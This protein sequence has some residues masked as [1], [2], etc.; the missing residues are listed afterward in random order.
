MK[1]VKL[2]K[3]YLIISYKKATMQHCIVYITMHLGLCTTFVSS[4]TDCCNTRSR[5]CMYI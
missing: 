4:G 2:S 3:T 1:F 5:K